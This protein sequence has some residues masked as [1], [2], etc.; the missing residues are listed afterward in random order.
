M[1][2]SNRHNT[3][4][5]AFVRPGH[6]AG[7]FLE[8]SQWKLIKE[9]PGLVELDIHLPSR[10]LNPYGELYG[11]FTGTYVDM[12][13]VYTLKTLFTGKLGLLRTSTVNMRMD[14]LEPI[15]EPNL[16][17][18]GTL[19]KEGRSTCLVSTEFIDYEGKLLVYAITTLRKILHT[20]R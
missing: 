11:G 1:K 9:E 19:L 6:C 8:S 5:P 18:H 3:I 7:D 4:P 17:L 16:L 15:V 13:A 2:S 10:V 12:V 20:N 14:Y